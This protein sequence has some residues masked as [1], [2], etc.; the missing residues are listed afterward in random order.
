M[1]NEFIENIEEPELRL[2]DYLHTIN[3]YKWLVILIFLVVF[4]SSFIYTARAPRIYNAT[5][6]VLIEDK[7]S[8]NLLFSTY[9]N[10]T[11][12]INNNIHILKSIPVLKIAHQFLQK[13]SNYESLPISSM[14]N[15]E[16]YLRNNMS[17]VTERDTD[18]LIINFQSISPEEARE[19]ANALANALIQQDT[20]YAR[21][22]FRST[23]EF[24]ANQLD[25]ED[26]RLRASEEDLRAYKIE[27]GISILS[28]ETQK[29]IE[30][31]SEIEVLL[32]A[33]EIDLKVSND[34]LTYLQAEL[35][36]Q[37]ELL[38][39]VN[40]ILTSPLLEKMKDEIVQNQSR[41]VN[42]LTRSD[43]SPNH[44]ELVSLSKTIENGK[45]KLNG[46]IK[47]IISVKSGSSDPLKYRSNLIEKISAARM[48]KNINESKVNSLLQAVEENNR[49]MAVLPDTEVE[50][51]R[52]ERNNAINVK[53]FTMLKEK[54]ADA[55]IAEKSKVGNIRIV[56]EARTPS[57]PIK[58]NKKMNMI[59][60]LM[61][62]VGMG[63]G[64]AL[65][66]HSFDPKIT[67]FDDVRKY[68]GLPILGTIPYISVSES[69]IE[70]IDKAMDLE[71]DSD[72]KKLEQFKQQIEARL[73]TNYAPKSSAS[74]AFRILRTNI[75]SKKIP[76]KPLS[77]VITSAGPKEGK[78]TI[79]SNMAIALAQT[80]AKT[81]LVDLDLRRPMVHNL[82]S[83][84]K[85]NGISD[86][87]TDPQ[88]KLDTFV[89][90]TDIPNLKI[91]TSGYI[92]PN[93][94]ELLGSP[95]MDEALA[96]LKSKYDYILLDS[97]P[98]IAV[99]D[100]MVLARKTD[101]L[102]LVVRIRR[103]DKMVIK[104]AKELLENIDITI[105]GA[106]INGI[107]P[108]KYYSSYEYN[109]Y[110]YYYYGKKEEKKKRFLPKFA[111]KNK[112]FS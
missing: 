40:S 93:P 27:H 20:D 32:S 103:A 71:N 18:I 35:S 82:F 21:I 11:S 85:E 49:R 22:E 54:Y 46:E 14:G 70:E 109:Y 2:T 100:T 37:D 8:N 88:A 68:V 72:R 53:I 9:S 91:I 1:K 31:S 15:P 50:L 17:V 98:V 23:R 61:L 7:V 67:T 26:R 4:G 101:M 43:Y 66:L 34:N 107:Y 33:A 44:P 24:L 10:R 102:T 63:V 25:E 58:P 81:I 36:S 42:L 78:T 28:E 83:F 3:R 60:A 62:G 29:L 97:P 75:I 45:E 74:E 99:T 95:R 112:P 13:S 110:Y 59:I 89:K 87:L 30:R 69:D 16:N 92:P 5:A 77:V 86:Y 111:R 6:K 104:R 90:S 73:I 76:D 48:D 39:D 55:Q 94:S 105:S 96:E 38:E 65:L 47:R 106:I 51:A 41:Y 19:V 12:S 84:K 64:A 57:A 56:E 52:L 80:G 108:Q 79:H